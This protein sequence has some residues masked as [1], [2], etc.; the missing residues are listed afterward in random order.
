MESSKPWRLRE[1]KAYDEVSEPTKG[2]YGPEYIFAPIKDKTLLTGRRP[3]E[4]LEAFRKRLSNLV[5][6][7]VLQLRKGNEAFQQEMN[8]RIAASS[9]PIMQEA[10]RR[11]FA[12]VYAAW[13]K[14]NDTD[15]VSAARNLARTFL[16]EEEKK[17]AVAD[18]AMRTRQEK[19]QKQIDENLQ[20]EKDETARQAE[21]AAVAA[22][23]APPV[24][25]AVAAGDKKEKTPYKKWEPPPFQ[26]GEVRTRGVYNP[27]YLKDNNPRGLPVC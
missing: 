15:P 6:E 10:I 25:A 22:A 19:I 12:D 1:K 20:K 3:D 26:P 2:A 24:P 18:E 9:E 4:K 8:D 16:D 17:E 13:Q 7:A 21:A 14:A 11:K 5:E 23:A 27:K